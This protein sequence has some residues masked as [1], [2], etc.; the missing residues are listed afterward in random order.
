MKYNKSL[1]ILT[2]F[3]P[4]INK[5]IIFLSNII[6]TILPK[7]IFSNK[8]IKIK[9]FK[10]RTFDNNKLS[11]YGFFP[12]DT[13]DKAMIY[14]HGGAF[15]LKASPYQYKLARKYALETN[16]NVF[17]VDYRRAPK[18]KYPI[19]V[20]DG[21]KV[22]EWICS[23]YKTIDINKIGFG[24]D[25]A[26][27]SIALSLAISLQNKYNIKPY[28]QFL[29]YPVVDNKI[30]TLSKK[31]YTN[32]PMWNSRLNK[33]M[34]EYYLGETEYDSPFNNIIYTKTY[35]EVCEYDCLRDE[36]IELYK[37]LK[38]N[39]INVVLNKTKGTMHGYDLLY[40]TNISKHN[41]KKRIGFLKQV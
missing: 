1:K 27:G 31:M 13:S 23:N 39:K 29:I 25:S 2:F 36:A 32:T 14:F 41:I 11:V 19:P 15:Y 5:F 18:F 40:N 12:T 8:K 17:F 7:M 28:F 10:I 38:K 26:G 16:L 21:E 33:Q 9:K 3:R 35:I 34:W 30:E 6:L 4:Y 37:L 22:Y 24:G 20:K